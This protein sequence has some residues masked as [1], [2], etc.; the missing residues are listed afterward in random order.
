M[1]MKIRET[2]PP[3]ERTITDKGKR[4]MDEPSTMMS[5]EREGGFTGIHGVAGKDMPWA[6]VRLR[7]LDM[8]VFKGDEGDDPDQWIRRVQRY[9]TVNRLNEKEKLEA[10][11]L[12]MDGDAV[13]WLRWEEDWT[14]IPSWEAF[15]RLLVERFR[16]SA[17]GNQYARLMKL[18][19]T[20][21]VRDYHCQF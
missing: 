12:C 19:Q 8:L 2:T 16:P 15:K 18:Q 14:L 20:T 17:Q 3:S 10:A 1:A 9:F 11:G 7:K 21:T 5:R 6:D 13:D 4:P